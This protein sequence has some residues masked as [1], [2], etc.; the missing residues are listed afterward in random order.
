LSFYRD[1]G[2]KC[3]FALIILVRRNIFNICINNK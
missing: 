2:L 3:D 1:E